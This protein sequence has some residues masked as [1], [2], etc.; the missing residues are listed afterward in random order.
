M[1][2]LAG[3]LRP[4]ASAALWVSGLF[5][6]LPNLEDWPGQSC[7][8]CQ[9][10]FLW[11]QEPLGYQAGCPQ[12]LH[13][14]APPLGTHHKSM[15]LNLDWLRVLLSTASQAALTVDGTSRSSRALNLPL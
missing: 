1:G 15:M 12:E 6:E 11:P 7:S 8:T 5:P 14:Y 10:I 4:L 13:F 9:S 2:T 3:A